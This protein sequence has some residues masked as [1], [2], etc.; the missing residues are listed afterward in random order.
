MSLA[1]TEFITRAFIALA[2]ALLPVLIWY[3]FDVILICASALLVS[4][5]LGL[6]AEPLVRWL[7][8]PP[9]IALVISTLVIFA[10][11]GGAAYL[12]GSRMVNE[13]HDVI[14]RAQS[15]QGTIAN[16][17]QSS[18]VGR[19]IL[20]HI[21]NRVDIVGFLPRVFSLSAAFVGGIVIAVVAGIFFA[22]QPR[23]Y[24]SGL[25]QLFP[26]HPRPE[27]DETVQYVG[28]ALRFWL[29][30]QLIQ[31]LLIGGIST[32]AVWL[33]GLPSPLAL[34]LIAGLA[35]FVPLVGPLVSAI[36]AIL[37]AATQ[38][39]HAVVWTIITYT[40][41]HQAEGHLITPVIQRYMLVI[42]PAVILLG[43]VAI[44]SL[45]GPA[46]IPLASPLAVI[47][48]VLINKLYV[49]DTLGE[50]SALSVEISRG[51]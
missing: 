21:R 18:D 49:S 44:G 39:P 5:L 45:F 42:P 3:L 4:G 40:L 34:G 16:S 36:P 7:R 29:L 24:L 28:R 9:R 41:I 6:G 2:I 46:A 37:V 11:L 48:F 15:G 30:G 32:V 10:V 25:V 31:M 27:A 50:K 35:E 38:S 22:A 51:R 23:L 47:V 13:L 20:G 1:R 19:E 26:P 14:Q 43:I 8:L 17:I 33:I 12:F